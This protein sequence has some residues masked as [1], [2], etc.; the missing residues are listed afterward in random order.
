[1]DQ[2]GKG[3]RTATD[4]ELE[5]AAPSK[6][7]A[8]G[9]AVAEDDD[10]EDEDSEE[11]EEDGEGE[12][13]SEE[14]EVSSPHSISVPSL[15]LILSFFVGGRTRRYG[16]EQHQGV[17]HSAAQANQLRVRGSPRQCRTHSQGTRR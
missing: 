6:D 11:E 4:A 9:K 1:M 14:E 3:K 5:E 2:K 7:K 8:K 15:V 16:H 17:S 12:D 13:D 10:E